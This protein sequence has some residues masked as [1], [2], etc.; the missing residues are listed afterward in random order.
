VSSFENTIFYFKILNLGL[1]VNFGIKIR[2]EK[3]FS[4]LL[5]C[6]PPFW[7]AHASWPSPATAL[8][9]A[10]RAP[11]SRPRSGTR[12]RVVAVRCRRWLG[13]V[14]WPPRPRSTSP[15][16]RLTQP[17]PLTS[18]PLPSLPHSSKAAERLS[19][20]TATPL[21]A[22]VGR[23]GHHHSPLEPPSSSEHRLPFAQP[24]LT[25]ACSGNAPIH[26]N[27]LPKF[28]PSSPENTTLWTPTLHSP[29]SFLH[30]HI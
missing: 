29:F 4:C 28:R 19:S 13:G 14:R 24:V 1:L 18:P 9:R 10:R 16:P 22:G 30:A 21:L 8:A 17:H 11:A 20:T 3:G 2:K 5:G 23:S 25:S 26:D 15:A 27:C 12:R 6:V 7:P